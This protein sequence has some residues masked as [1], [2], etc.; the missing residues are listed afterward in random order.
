MLLQ[1][2]PVNRKAPVLVHDGKSPAESLVTI[3][4]INETW[5]QNPLLPYDHYETAKHD[6]GPEKLIKGFAD[7]LIGWLG[8]WEPIVEEIVVINRI[9]KEFMDKLDSWFDD[10]LSFLLSKNACR[11]VMNSLTTR[12]SHRA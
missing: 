9:D 4:Y 10:F 2:N 6:S 3:E 12:P 1:Y 11:L 8:C 7:I 5:K